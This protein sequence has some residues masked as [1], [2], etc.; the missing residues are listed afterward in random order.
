MGLS[1]GVGT[2]TGF[3]PHISFTRPADTTV[4]TANDV[5][6]GPLRFP[7]LAP[8]GANFFLNSALLRIFRTTVIVSETTYVL[9]LYSNKPPSQLAD[10][11]A[12]TVSAA[13]APFYLGQID[14]P[15]VL[16]LGALVWS[17]VDNLQMQR[18]LVQAAS[19]TAPEDEQGNWLHAY[20]V[21]VGGYTPES[22]T[23]HNLSVNGHYL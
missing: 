2:L 14:L 8:F 15:Q 13:D 22:G 4:Y 18:K 23:V 16:D 11:A 7:F 21:T 1:V 19:P 10:N 5:V 9:H 6:G 17:K 12:F 20:L 3:G